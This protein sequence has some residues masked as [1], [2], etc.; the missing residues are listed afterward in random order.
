M[1]TTKH[2]WLHVDVNV[3]TNNAIG[4]SVILSCVRA[5]AIGNVAWPPFI[6]DPVAAPK[7]LGQFG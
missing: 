4:S 6:K 2:C 1:K 3:I 7:L 5:L